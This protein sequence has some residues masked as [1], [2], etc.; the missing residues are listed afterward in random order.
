MR[1]SLFALPLLIAL[2]GCGGGSSDVNSASPYAGTYTGTWVSLTDTSDAGT[3]TWTVGNDGTISGTDV[4]PGR[5]TTFSIAGRIDA[6][7]NVTTTSTPAGGGEAA[8]LNGRLVFEIEGPLAG[9]LTW[10]IA[11]PTSYRYAFTRQAN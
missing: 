8:T 5:E 1:R 9:T 11:T 4:D 7:G 2:A 3:A 10:N 6:N